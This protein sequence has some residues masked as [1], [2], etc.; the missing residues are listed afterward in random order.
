VLK[1]LHAGLLPYLTVSV[2]VFV[3]FCICM[4]GCG[5]WWRWQWWCIRQLYI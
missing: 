2:C 5:W 3:C 4:L 1:D